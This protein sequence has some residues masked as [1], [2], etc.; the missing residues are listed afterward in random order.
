MNKHIGAPAPYDVARVREDF[1]ILSTEVYG[2]PLVYL[3][4]GAS[5]Q[6]PKAVVDRMV[7]ATYHEYANV[8]RGLHFL[9]NAA[10]DAFEAARESVRSFLNAESV[11]E[12]V[13]TKS[14]TEAIN[15]IAAS[16]GQ[17]FIEPGPPVALG[18][19]AVGL[20]E[21][22][23]EDVE[24]SK[25][26]ARLDQRRGDLPA[27]F[28]IFNHAR[29]GDQKQ[30]ARRIE[31]FPDG[32]G[33]EHAEV[34]AAKRGKVN[35]LSRNHEGRWTM[36]FPSATSDGTTDCKPALLDLIR[37]ARQGTTRVPL[38]TPTACSS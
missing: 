17:A 37:T 38:L 1:P 26:P 6:K 3:D 18:G 22:G 34:L 21:T 11:N 29:P 20:V 12:I 28:F 2:K 36:P 7:E 30:L 4:N 35:Q 32:G 13:F 8:H 19:G 25:L 9:A 27:K 31:I 24:N 33:V 5:A 23:F 15:L 16:F 10:T 14:A